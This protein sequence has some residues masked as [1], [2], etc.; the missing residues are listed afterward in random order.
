MIKVKSPIQ[1][2]TK[3]CFKLR[4]AI[5]LPQLLSD[6]LPKENRVTFKG[7][8]LEARRLCNKKSNLSPSPQAPRILDGKKKFKRS[9]IAVALPLKG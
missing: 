2:G 5:K 4:K 3:K 6:S 7:S 8:K 9:K 1:K